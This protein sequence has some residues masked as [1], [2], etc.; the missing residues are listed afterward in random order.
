MDNVRVFEDT[1][2][3]ISSIPFLS[4][5]V[6]RS[7]ALQMVYPEDCSVN[8]PDVRRYGTSEVILVPH[9]SFEAAAGLKGRT[10]V[11]NFASFTNPGGG[12]AYGSSAQE[13][14][15]CRISTLYECI[16]DDR[17]M[18]GFYFPHSA[19]T[20]D[21]FNSDLIYTPGVTVFKSD[22]LS[23]EM[24]PREKWFQADV[25]TCAAPDLSSM[26][27]SDT[28]LRQAHV[29]RFS[30]IL[31]VCAENGDENVVLGAFGCGVFNNDPWIVADAAMEVVSEFDGC[32][33]K[34]VFAVYCPPGDSSNYLAFESVLKARGSHPSSI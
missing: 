31:S 26:S 30:R 25:V 1:L 10:A 3:S 2:N 28:R 19:V 8:V 4:E 6:E 7:R 15:L 24:L 9:R 23:P 17:M 34:I 22:T 32:F 5:S 27:V 18:E 29:Q 33:A 11:L 20:S 21:L 12:V 13:E 14:S 16:T